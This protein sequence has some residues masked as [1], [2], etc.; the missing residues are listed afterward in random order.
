MVTAMD[1]SPVSVHP[2]AASLSAVRDSLEAAVQMCS[3]RGLKKSAR[4]ASEQL[5]G[6]TDT[7]EDES[8]PLSAFGQAGTERVR[9]SEASKIRLG[10]DLLASGEYLRCV[11]LLSPSPNSDGTSDLALFLWGYARYLAGEQGRT[12]SV[13]EGQDGQNLHQNGMSK[14]FQ[15]GTDSTEG[16]TTTA[17]TGSNRRRSQARRAQGKYGVS[18]AVNGNTAAVADERLG[19]R[20][21]S[22]NESLEELFST[23]RKHMTN[24]KCED[25]ES[26][27]L[28]VYLLAVVTRDLRRE[29]GVPLSEA[30]SQTTSDSLHKSSSSIEA[31][32]GDPTNCSSSALSVRELFLR[33]AAMYPWNW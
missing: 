31:K 14:S 24:T 11:Y 5:L 25:L 13:C 32:A 7:A 9:R 4:W 28:L 1:S 29:C 27:G 17:V 21:N 22:V 20:S 6:M 33:S 8:V 2:S 19:P 16:S 30:M 10:S 12:Q 15:Q 26:R 23:L 18:A 3:V